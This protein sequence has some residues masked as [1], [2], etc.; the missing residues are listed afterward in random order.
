MLSK[1]MSASEALSLIDDNTLLGLG[2][3]GLT[4]NP[5]ALVA[6]LILLEKKD[7]NLVCSPIGGL[8]V[9]MLIGAG[10]VA[11]VEFAQISFEELGM[12]PSFRHY[13]QNGTLKILDHT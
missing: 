6:N 11:S 12:A 7:L 9:D 1:V 13:A 3:S 2:G 4:M 5:V 8:A 10:S